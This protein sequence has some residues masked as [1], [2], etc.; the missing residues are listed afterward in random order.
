MTLATPHHFYIG[1]PVWLQVLIALAL[2]G[3]AIWELL[4]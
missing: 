2:L 3:C 4:R 1:L